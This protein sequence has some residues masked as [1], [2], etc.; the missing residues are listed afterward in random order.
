MRSFPFHPAMSAAA[1]AAVAAAASGPSRPDDLDLSALL[2]PLSREQVELIV[3]VSA[4]R[5]QHAL[6]G[7]ASPE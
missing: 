6:R 5:A 1:A 2:A 4:R 7:D 3:V